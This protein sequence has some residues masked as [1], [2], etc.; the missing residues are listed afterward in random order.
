M[1][2]Q[3][4]LD[5]RKRLGHTI[6]TEIGD[7][8]VHR[9]LRPSLGLRVVQRPGALGTEGLKPPKAVSAYMAEIGAKG[10]KAKGKRKTR[11]IEHYRK[12][13]A[14]RWAKKEPK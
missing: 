13:A 10:G 7:S 12:A 3:I 6:P 4:T 11:P 9:Q 2:I 1:S 14:K 5:M 8:H